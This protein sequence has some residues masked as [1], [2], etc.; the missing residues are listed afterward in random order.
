[1]AKGCHASKSIVDV[2]LFKLMFKEEMLLEVLP[3]YR[4]P[5]EQ[6]KLVHYALTDHASYR[7]RLGG[8][9]DEACDRQW[10]S[11]VAQVAREF[12]KFV[13]VRTP[14]RRGRDGKIWA[15]GVTRRRGGRV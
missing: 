12:I 2:F 7:Q 4:L 14:E 10:I 6:V 3:S 8:F 5:V 1:M 13:E 9:R 11:S 15:G